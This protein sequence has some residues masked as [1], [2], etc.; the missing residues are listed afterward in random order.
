MLQKQALAS[1]IQR[2]NWDFV[3]DMEKKK[4]IIVLGST[5][6]IGKSTLR[7]A[8]HLSSRI[9]VVAIAAASDIETLESQA[10]EFDVKIVGVLDKKKALELQKKIPHIKVVAGAEGIEEVASFSDAELCVCAISGTL[11]VSPTL[12]AI[13]AK[14]DVAI[15][16]KEALVSAGEL[17]MNAAKENGVKVLP[18]DSEQSAI[19]Q[20]LQGAKKEEVRRLILTASGGPF[21]HYSLD[22]MQSINVEEALCHPTWKMG[23][24]NTI[25][26]STLM[27]KGLEVIEAHFLFDIPLEKIDVVVHPQSLV[28][29]FVEFQDGSLL[30]QVSENQM[31]IPIQYSLTYPERLP[32]M[33]PAF[34]FTKFSKFEFYT[35]DLDKFSCLRLAYEALKQGG[36]LPCYMNAANEI[37]VSRFLQGKISWLDIAKKLEKLMLAH[38]VIKQVQIDTLSFIDKQAREEALLA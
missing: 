28:H 7:V 24:K 20:C 31:T 9:Q 23:P 12:S 35:P 1:Y 6:S 33:V 37:L 38:S 15:A 8:R 4:N 3:L 2:L 17:I 29:S 19:F 16:N 25:D 5:G 13:K 26:S 32:G 11:G 30:A 27:N 21:F 22:K 34:D 10:K 18:I 36:S 14:H